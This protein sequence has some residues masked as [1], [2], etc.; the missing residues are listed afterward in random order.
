MYAE[1]E[2]RGLHRTPR[3]AR[4]ERRDGERAETRAEEGRLR[5]PDGESPGTYHLK[6]RLT[7][8]GQ[9]VPWGRWLIPLGSDL[10]L[11]AVQI[12]P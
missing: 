9:P 5:A 3:V 10:D 2:L 7:R 4:I 11:G 8:D 1:G 6:M 12:G